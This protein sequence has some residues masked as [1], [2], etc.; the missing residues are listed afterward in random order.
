MAS[1]VV[2]ANACVVCVRVS[3]RESVWAGMRELQC[4]PTAE[5]VTAVSLLDS[6]CPPQCH[7]SDPSPLEDAAVAG[8]AGGQHPLQDVHRGAL[9]TGAVLPVATVVGVFCVFVG[10][11]AG[12]HDVTRYH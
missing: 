10:V 2:P 9:K 8:E 4:A 12:H 1:G 11:A 7:P 5:H 3:S 6:K